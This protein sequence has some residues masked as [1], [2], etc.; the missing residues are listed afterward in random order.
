MPSHAGA[1]RFVAGSPLAER[2][3]TTTLTPV[4]SH[5]QKQNRPGSPPA[6]SFVSPVSEAISI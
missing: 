2:G 5:Q 4:P 1:P 3:A 6:G